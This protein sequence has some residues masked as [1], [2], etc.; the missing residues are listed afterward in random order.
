MS[1][2]IESSHKSIDSISFLINHSPNSTS[3]AP[4]SSEPPYSFLLTMHPPANDTV[5]PL[6]DGGSI[7]HLRTLCN[8]P[9]TPSGLDNAHKLNISTAV[10]PLTWKTMSKDYSKN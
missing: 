9:S 8:A 6:Y 1:L 4:P 2:Q 3:L 5:F 7:T 10:G